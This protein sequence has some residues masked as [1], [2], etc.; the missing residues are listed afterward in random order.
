MSTCKVRGGARRAVIILRRAKNSMDLFRGC[1]RGPGSAS[2]TSSGSQLLSL[3]ST[4]PAVP[5]NKNDK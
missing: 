3:L 4:I 5:A 1:F 2:H